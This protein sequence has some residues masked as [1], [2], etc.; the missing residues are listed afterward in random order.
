MKTTIARVLVCSSVGLLCACTDGFGGSGYPKA[1]IDAEC[2]NSFVKVDRQLQ[3]GDI[4]V[5]RAYLQIM[6]GADQTT[7]IDDI[8]K[9]L[10]NMN[11]SSIETANTKRD[12][13]YLVNRPFIDD[14][15]AYVKVSIQP[16]GHPACRS[17]RYTATYPRLAWPWLRGLGLKAEDCI[18]VESSNVITA[19]TAIF[20]SEQSINKQQNGLGSQDRLEVALHD[21]S[22]G[23]PKI[24]AEMVDVTAYGGGGEAGFHHFFPCA[25]HTVNDQAFRQAIAVI[26]NPKIAVPVF[27]D[28]PVNA[29]PAAWKAVD[30]RWLATLQW[31]S[32]PGQVAGGTIVNKQGTVWVGQRAAGKGNEPAFYSLVDGKLFS[33]FIP[34]P[35]RGQD[36]TGLARSGK[37]YAFIAT[38]VQHR[39]ATSYI[40]E[41]DTQ[42]RFLTMFSLSPEQYAQLEDKK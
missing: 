37:G 32:R 2:R 40:Y 15:Q 16:L 11:L 20:V 5:D 25:T 30:P 18:A 19:N 29:L 42:G 4:Y 6:T 8:V 31:H 21:L 34:I 36:I 35:Q 10:F 41:Y 38:M 12:Y 33:S 1:R 27:V 24:A 28:V 23:T 13:P 26:P 3:T 22:G 7:G 39:E 14:S 17:F 9:L